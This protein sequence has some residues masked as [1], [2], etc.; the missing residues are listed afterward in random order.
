[1]GR[2]GT[3]IKKLGSDARMEIEKFLTTKV[4]LELTVKVRDNWRDDERALQWF[5]Y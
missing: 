2:K 1:L 5:G 4:F 3:A